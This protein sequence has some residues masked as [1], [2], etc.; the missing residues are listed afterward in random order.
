MKRATIVLK[1]VSFAVFLS[2]PSITPCGPDDAKKKT[3]KPVTDARVYS[4]SNNGP[5]KKAEWMAVSDVTV[6]KNNISNIALPSRPQ[7][8]AQQEWDSSEQA[9]ANKTKFLSWACWHLL[10]VQQPLPGQF[11][12][13]E[14]KTVCSQLAKHRAYIIHIVHW[15]RVDDKFSLRSNDWYVFRTKKTVLVQADFTPD[16]EPVLDADNDALLF[17]IHVFDSVVD[18]EKALLNVTYTATA[19]RTVPQNLQ[20]LAQLVQALVGATAKTPNTAGTQQ[21]LVLVALVP[22]AERLPFKLVFTSSLSIKEK[23]KPADPPKKVDRSSSSLV[24]PQMFQEAVLRTPIDDANPQAANGGAPQ[25]PPKPTP[26]KPDSAT[27]T[28]IDCSALDSKSKP[29]TMSHTW[30]SNE[31]EWW[32]VSLGVAVPGVKQTKFTAPSGKVVA[33]TTTHTDVYAFFDLGYDLQ[34]RALR[35]PHLEVGI[36]V[37]SQP[38]YR[39]FVGVGEWITPLLGLEKKKF[40]LRLGV[41][42][43]A[44]IAKQY[45]PATLGVGST[46]TAGDLTTDLRSHRVTK[47]LYGLDFSVSELIGRIK[48]KSK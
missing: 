1:L 31:R 44:V 30:Q 36:P 41:F 35:I 4:F 23:P 6:I 27:P 46:A 24:M 22:G 47:L 39:P 16:G 3:A 26:D 38:L 19:T 48:P 42:V 15:A 32:D 43:G 17:G 11:Q 10:Q 28:A 2:W 20:N 12:G 34:N 40:P 7:L 18:E 5:N 21:A 37:A 29:C 45:S 8:D 9:P 14:L 25:T 33:S 13:P